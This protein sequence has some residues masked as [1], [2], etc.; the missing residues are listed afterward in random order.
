MRHPLTLPGRFLGFLC[1]YVVQV[2]LSAGAVLHDVLT[3]G[4]QATP[5]VVRMPLQ[6]R[7]DVQVAAIGALI[8]LT[9]GTLTL[10]VVEHPG[11]R[12]LLVHSMYDPDNPTAVANLRDMEARM[13]TA[14]TLR[15]GFV[16]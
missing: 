3:P 5:R 11:G 12:D 4:R 2:L 9:P 1:W 6:S 15:G 10:G 7:T 8:T 16:P 14:I 13:L